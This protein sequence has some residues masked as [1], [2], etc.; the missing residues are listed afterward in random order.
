MLGRANAA[1][2]TRAKNA[3]AVSWKAILRP[4]TKK[5]DIDDDENEAQIGVIVYDKENV[6]SRGVGLRV[7]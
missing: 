1:M 5:T 7:R 3:L 4:Y 2:T 6:S